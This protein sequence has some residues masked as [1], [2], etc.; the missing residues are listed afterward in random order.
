M[1]IMC[2][3]E[4]RPKNLHTVI[5]AKGEWIKFK[6]SPPKVLEQHSQMISIAAYWRHFCLRSNKEY[7]KKDQIGVL[8]FILWYLLL[9]MLHNLEHNSL[10]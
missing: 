5:K 3:E 9:K 7:E 4:G 8:A 2:G 1:E 10:Y 6:N